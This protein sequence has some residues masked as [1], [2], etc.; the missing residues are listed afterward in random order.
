MDIIFLCAANGSKRGCGLWLKFGSDPNLR[1]LGIS[2]FS[3]G[4]LM[5][6]SGNL[7]IGLEGGMPEIKD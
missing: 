3:K 5:R 1:V 4:G 7:P 6:F 2:G